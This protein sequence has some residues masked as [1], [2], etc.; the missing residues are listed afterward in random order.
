MISRTTGSRPARAIRSVLGGACALGLISL[1]GAAMAD[2]PVSM[3]PP[4]ST[5]AGPADADN[6]FVWTEIP[7]DQRVPITRGVFD[8]NG[9]QLFDDVGETINVPFE[10]ENLY[11]MKFAESTDGTMYF[12]NEGNTP[13]LYVPKNGYL[14]NSAASGAKWYPFSKD[15][16]PATP[17]FLG[18]A[19]SW[20]AFIHMGWYPGMVTI[21]GYWGSRPY[22]A[23]AVFAAAI[24][25]TFIIGGHHYNGWEPYH[26]YYRAHPSPYRWGHPVYAGHVFHGGHPIGDHGDHRG[27]GDH[28]GFDGHGDSGGHHDG[29]G[30]VFRGGGHDGGRGGDHDHRR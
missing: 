20:G 15:F 28:H 16:H 19:P 22:V 25:L 3:A 5:T 26:T 17:V 1:A 27:P 21:G 6:V 18:V 13:V 7:K 9:Y 8:Q 12:V 2:S 4:V 24:G 10:N 14:E 11:V 29:G 23:G 30:H